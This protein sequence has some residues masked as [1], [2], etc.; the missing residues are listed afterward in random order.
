MDKSEAELIEG[1]KAKAPGHYTERDGGYWYCV[2][3]DHGGRTG[4]DFKN[5]SDARRFL[6]WLGGDPL[7]EGWTFERCGDG[8][9]TYTLR[10]PD[11]YVEATIWMR[12]IRRLFPARAA[13]IEGK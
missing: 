11:Q 12:E 9:I 13:E 10:I 8:R 6:C 1:V 3:P 7:P 4:E 5:R 2:T